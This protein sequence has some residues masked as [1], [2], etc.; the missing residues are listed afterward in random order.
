M[1]SANAFNLNKA[2]FLSSDKGLTLPNDKVL[3]CRN[4]KHMQTSN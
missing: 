4:R 3:D 1:L 2:L